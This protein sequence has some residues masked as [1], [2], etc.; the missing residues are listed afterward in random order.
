MHHIIT[1]GNN[2]YKQ[3]LLELIMAPW[4][5]DPDGKVKLFN[6]LSC[7]QR[8]KERHKTWSI[9]IKLHSYRDSYSD[10]FILT[11][12]SSSSSGGCR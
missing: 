5:F 8:C 1:I 10:I 7:S 12:E 9:A 11:Q 6:K 4:S 3:L 2:R